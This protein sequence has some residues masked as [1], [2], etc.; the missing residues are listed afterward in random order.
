MNIETKPLWD[1]PAKENIN[2]S[3]NEVHLWELCPSHSYI[4]SLNSAERGRCAAITDDEVKVS[5]ATSQAGLRRIASRYEKC[6]NG[7][8]I[9][10]RAERGKPYIDGGPEFNLSHTAGRIFAAFSCEPVGLDVESASRPVHADSLAAKFF[11]K[12]EAD[13]LLTVNDSLR[14]RAFLRYWVCKEAMVKLSGD[15]IYHGLRDALVDLREG[16][17][18]GGRYCGREV[19]IQEFCPAPGFLAALASWQ[20]LE[21]KCFF[22]I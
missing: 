2:L 10:K 20:P 5:Y 14:K 21:V 4:E 15:G 17:R 8:V 3:G 19:W 7:E 11:S 16:G 22:R 13:C 12:A 18:S 1:E 6:A 9:M